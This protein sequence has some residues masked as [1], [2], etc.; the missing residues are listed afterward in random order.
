M[1]NLNNNNNRFLSLLSG[2]NRATAGNNRLLPNG[3]DDNVDNNNDDI[4]IGIASCSSLFEEDNDADAATA[5]TTGGNNNGNDERLTDMMFRLWGSTKNKSQEGNNNMEARGQYEHHQ[6]GK[7]VTQGQVQVDKSWSIPLSSLVDE[8]EV[9]QQQRQAG[10]M[11]LSTK[12]DS[13]WAKELYE[14]RYSDR[15][16]INDELH[17]K[18]IL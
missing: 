5:V 4:S 8:D 9:T 17:G 10:D 3:D 11:S 6:K 15:E 16:R 12:V 14:M 7:A 2:R 13:V 1:W 18:Y